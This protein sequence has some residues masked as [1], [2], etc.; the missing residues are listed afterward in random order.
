MKRI[1]C[2][3]AAFSSASAVLVLLLAVAADATA[4]T[5]R[6]TLQ[7]PVEGRGNPVLPQDQAER[8][9]VLETKIVELHRQ[10]KFDEAIPLA[11]EILDLRTEHQTGWSDAD[12]EPAEWY[13]IGDARRAIEELRLLE[14]LSPAQRAELAKVDGADAKIDRHYGQGR[15]GAALP[16]ARVQLSI[17][18]RVLGDDHTDTLTSFDYLVGRLYAQGRYDEAEPLLVEILKIRRRLL[19][20][21]HPN[22]LRTMNNLGGLYQRQGRAGEAEPFLLEAL[23][24]RR[25]VLGNEAVGHHR[26]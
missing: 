12:G 4:Q 20:E 8:V 23:A 24:G 17:R 18:R 16:F 5:D 15:Y 2:P 21:E 19:G 6:R 1:S 25:R 22:T 26:S 11:Q 7:P 10:E 14:S 9:A 3:R 13:E